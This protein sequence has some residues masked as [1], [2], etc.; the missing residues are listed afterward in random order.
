MSDTWE[1]EIQ[2]PQEYE[3]MGRDMDNRSKDNRPF[4]GATRLMFWMLGVF[5]LGGL[6]LASWVGNSLVD[7]KAEV[8]SLKVEV[9]FIIEGKLK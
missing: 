7:L 2:S 8:E 1:Y 3:R 6:A 9:Q 4:N 5:A